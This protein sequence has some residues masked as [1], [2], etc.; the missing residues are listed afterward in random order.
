MAKFRSA[1]AAHGTSNRAQSNMT[2]SKTVKRNLGENEDLKDEIIEVPAQKKTKTGAVTIEEIPNDDDPQ[3][4]RDRPS[5]E[6]ELGKR[7]DGITMLGSDHGNRAH[8]EKMD[9]TCLRLLS[10]QPCRRFFFLADEFKWV[11]NEFGIITKV[12]ESPVNV[13][14]DSPGSHQSSWALRLTTL[15]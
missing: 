12:S 1:P 14:S 9:I 5:M 7:S 4:A 3:S 11:L 13:F 15:E 10:P 6:G 2:Q 8:V